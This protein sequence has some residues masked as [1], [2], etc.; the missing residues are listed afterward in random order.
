MT[1]SPEPLDTDSNRERDGDMYQV[2]YLVKRSSYEFALSIP[3][4]HAACLSGEHVLFQARFRDRHQEQTIV[5]DL[6]ALEDFY[7]SLSRLME[8]VK[9]ERQKYS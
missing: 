3:T 9:I 5:L 7:E 2:V 6:T 4:T 8:Y 1:R